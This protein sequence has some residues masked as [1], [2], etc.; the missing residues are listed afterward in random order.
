MVNSFAA[1]LDITVTINILQEKIKILHKKMLKAINLYQFHKNASEK[2][3]WLNGYSNESKIN[4]GSSYLLSSKN[5]LEK[6]ELRLLSK[7]MCRYNIYCGA[8]VVITTVQFYSSI[9]FELKF[10]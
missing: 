8:V 6:V 5:F 3:T 10:C 2:S 1:S 7:S 9:K 4:R